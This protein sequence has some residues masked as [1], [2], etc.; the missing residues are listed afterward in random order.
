MLI[1]K[2]L[3]FKIFLLNTS[4]TEWIEIPQFSNEEKVYK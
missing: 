4:L 1:I 3:I 2:I